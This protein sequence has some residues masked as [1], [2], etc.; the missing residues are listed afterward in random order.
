M[1]TWHP[2]CTAWSVAR[3]SPSLFILQG[4]FPFHLGQRG[5]GK[6]F[7]FSLHSDQLMLR[8]QALEQKAASR[9]LRAAF[10]WRS[11]TCSPAVSKACAWTTGLAPSANTKNAKTGFM[12]LIQ[13]PD[14][15]MVTTFMKLMDAVKNYSFT[16]FLQITHLMRFSL[17]LGLLMIQSVV[18]YV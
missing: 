2:A 9:T 18:A 1:S 4:G 13:H 11:F 8:L 6:H 16:C 10:G 12:Q 17:H 5:Q 7:G 14:A 3:I 15:T